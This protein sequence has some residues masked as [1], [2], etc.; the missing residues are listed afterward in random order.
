MSLHTSNY[1]E[2]GAVLW[3]LEME[4]S[5]GGLVRARGNLDFRLL[6]A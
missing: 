4:R 6:R 5:L 3:L 2:A 1:F